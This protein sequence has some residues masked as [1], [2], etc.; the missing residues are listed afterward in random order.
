MSFAL[1]RQ[2]CVISDPVSWISVMIFVGLAFGVI[3]CTAVCVWVGLCPSDG[4]CGACFD[5][6][7]AYKGT[8]GPFCCCFEGSTCSTADVRRAI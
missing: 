2:G 5:A 6:A 7:R 1:D 8:N 4:W 3:F